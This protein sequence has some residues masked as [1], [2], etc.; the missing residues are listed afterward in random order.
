MPHPELEIL[1]QLQELDTEASR[2][3]AEVDRYP[4][5]CKAQEDEAERARQKHADALQRRKNLELEIRQSEQDAD[6]CHD[7]LN[8]LSGQQ[9]NV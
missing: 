2:M 9:F 7:T 5:L 8:K 1:L 3:Q 6:A 4:A